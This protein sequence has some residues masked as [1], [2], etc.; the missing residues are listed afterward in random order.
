MA[1]Q[2]IVEKN[3]FSVDRLQALPFFTPRV[4]RSLTELSIKDNSIEKK[5]EQMIGLFPNL[6]ILRLSGSQLQSQETAQA[7]LQLKNLQTL[8]LNYAFTNREFLATICSITT[9]EELNYIPTNGP[10]IDFEALSKLPN[11]RCFQGPLENDQAAIALSRIQTIQV[12]II[13]GSKITQ[14]GLQALCSLPRLQEIVLNSIEIDDQ[15]LLHLSQAKTLKKISFLGCGGISEK[16][17]LQ[18]S[19]LNQLEELDV[20]YTDAIRTVDSFAGFTS[21]RKLNF[22]IVSQEAQKNILHLKEKK[23]ELNVQYS[24]SPY[25]RRSSIAHTSTREED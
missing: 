19:T 11:L 23:P 17:I 4:C 15:M 16:G 1:I 20:A 9:L 3:E 25:F 14:K 18:L 10:D 7:L 22:G 5:T 2:H 13:S 6:R 8:D 21:L 24:R 12:L